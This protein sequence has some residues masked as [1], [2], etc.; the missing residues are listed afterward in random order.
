MRD[1]KHRPNPGL[2]PATTAQ[3]YEEQAQ[4]ED[5]QG[6]R[7]DPKRMNDRTLRNW[8]CDVA[9]AERCDRCRI[10]RYG[11]E[12]VERVKAKTWRYE[13]DYTGT[14]VRYSRKAKAVVHF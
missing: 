8:L 13:C 12:F 9:G 14:I 11:V 3:K 4:F 1:Y 5:V 10:C 6:G 2:I 7:Y